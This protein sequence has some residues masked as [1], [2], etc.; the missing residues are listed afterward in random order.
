M[1]EEGRQR[2]GKTTLTTWTGLSL[3]LLLQLMDGKDLCWSVTRG[4][5]SGIPTIPVKW[6]VIE[7]DGWDCCIVIRITIEGCPLKD[8]GTE[9]YCSTLLQALK[10]DIGLNWK[11]HIISDMRRIAVAFSSWNWCNILSFFRRKKCLDLFLYLFFSFSSQILFIASLSANPDILRKFS[12]LEFSHVFVVSVYQLSNEAEQT[13]Q[14]KRKLQ[15]F[16]QP[17]HEIQSSGWILGR[18]MLL[19]EFEKTF[20]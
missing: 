19:S 5:P 15:N 17:S 6:L 2:T 7:G 14:G 12:M 11:H 3:D 13:A 20:P 8:A 4:A 16:C 10:G 1:E 9:L 18:K